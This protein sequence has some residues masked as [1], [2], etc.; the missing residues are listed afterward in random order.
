[1]WKS[2]N[3]KEVLVW[4]GFNWLKTMGADKVTRQASAS[5]YFVKNNINHKKYNY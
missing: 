4:N 1:M 3:L 2:L 5:L